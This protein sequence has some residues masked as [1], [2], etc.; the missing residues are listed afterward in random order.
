MKQKIVLSLLCVAIVVSGLIM[1]WPLSF[2]DAITSDAAMRIDVTAHRLEGNLLTGTSETYILQPDSEEFLQIQR[3]LDE[4]PYHRSFRSFSRHASISNAGSVLWISQV[5]GDGES[6][7]VV[8]ADNGEVIVNGHV[9]RMG[10]WGNQ[11]ALAVMGEIVSILEKSTEPDEITAKRATE[12][13]EAYLESHYSQETIA[14]ITN[15]DSPLV[16]K[17]DLPEI[18]WSE[19][20][21]Q[22]TWKVTYTTTLDGLLGPIAFYIDRHTGAV[23][24]Y[25]LRM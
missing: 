9:Y 11:Q 6:R 8:L 18:W 1:L 20:G 21:S 13:A 10:Y 23:S 4:Y 17:S 19:H 5:F 15:Y 16:A 3:L 2:A 22:P 7:Q 14:A 24:G 12:I 25:D